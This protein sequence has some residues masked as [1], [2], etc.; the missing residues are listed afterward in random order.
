MCNSSECRCLQHQLAC[1]KSAGLPPRRESMCSVMQ[2]FGG[3]LE[4]LEAGALRGWDK[5]Y[6]LLAAILLADQFTR[7]S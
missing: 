3:D 7:Y 4:A 6:E 5:P 2:R 1:H